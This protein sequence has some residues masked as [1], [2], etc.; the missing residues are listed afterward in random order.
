M[1]GFHDTIKEHGH[2]LSA[3]EHGKIAILEKGSQI[4]PPTLKDNFVAIFIGRQSEIDTQ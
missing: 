4:L 3:E 2:I 1:K